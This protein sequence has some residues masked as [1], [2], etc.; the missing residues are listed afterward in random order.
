[1]RL[2]HVVPCSLHELRGGTGYD[3]RPRLHNSSWMTGIFVA[4][5]KMCGL[6]PLSR[7]FLT[8]LLVRG[9]TPL[10]IVHWQIQG[11]STRARL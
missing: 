5:D 1:M 10:R 9:V 2:L 8:V 6:I 11:E 7:R 4:I 3:S